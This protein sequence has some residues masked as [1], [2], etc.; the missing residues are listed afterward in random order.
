M[1]DSH[2]QLVQWNYISKT[3][4]RYNRN[5]CSCPIRGQLICVHRCIRSLRGLDVGTLVV[6]ICMTFKTQV[7]GQSKSLKIVPFSSCLIIS[8]FY[9]NLGP[10]MHHLATMDGPIDIHHVSVSATVLVGNAR[11]HIEIYSCNFE[12]S[13]TLEQKQLLLFMCWCLSF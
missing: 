7:M 3:F 6:N 13:Y 4:L 12:V 10:T 5:I 11:K 2:L 9:S 1:T 8:N